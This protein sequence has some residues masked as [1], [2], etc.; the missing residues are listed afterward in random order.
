MLGA[1]QDRLVVNLHG[2]GEPSEDVTPFE[3][4]YWCARS[5]WPRLADALSEIAE[6]GKVA[7]EITFDDGYL[8]DY[9]LGL[10]ALQER[11]LTATFFVSAGNVGRHGFMRAEH[12]QE[13]RDARM[14]I[15][16][17]GWSHIDL[18]RLPPTDLTR[19]TV[20]SGRRIS[21][22]AET[23]VTAFAIPFGSYDRVVLRSLRGYEAVYTSDW[24]RAR[25]TDWLIP[26]VSYANDVWQPADLPRYAYEQYS[27][28]STLRRRL[29]AVY[30]SLR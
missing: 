13:L 3:R 24:V 7:L 18:R 26:R 27:L 16:S 4:R 14:G 5:T 1:P 12:L 10:P 9:E 25:R 15:G 22:L 30:K 6:N 29:V 2:I 17:H 11:N 28:R 8:S 23:P 20:D 19:E 21:E